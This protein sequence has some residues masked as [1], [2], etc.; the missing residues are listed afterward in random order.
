MQKQINE[1]IVGDII[2]DI[3]RKLLFLEKTPSRGVLNNIH[4]LLKNLGINNIPKL[5][6]TSE[7]CIEPIN[8]KNYT[9]EIL[10]I[11]TQKNFNEIKK[12]C[13]NQSDTYIFK[14]SNLLPKNVYISKEDKKEKTDRNFIQEEFEV[15]SD[16]EESDNSELEE[17]GYEQ[18][19]E[20]EDE[21]SD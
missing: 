11:L 21:F 17:N 16:T 20:N 9:N 19:S 13:L 12:E 15:E 8:L 5:Y 10:D 3:K 2:G 1:N 6:I 14:E 18:Y 4:I 7:F